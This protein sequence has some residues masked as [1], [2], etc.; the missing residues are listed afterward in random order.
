MFDNGEEKV[1]EIYS[2]VVKKY[3]DEFAF[4][5][6]SGISNVNQNDGAMSEG[7]V[8]N[9]KAMVR[10]RVP[11]NTPVMKE[12]HNY[13][14]FPD[15]PYYGPSSDFNQFN[16]GQKGT[17]FVLVI[18]AL[19]ALVILVSVVTFSILKTLGM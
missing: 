3:Q 7:G 13:S 10:V 8:A 5:K 16:P 2:D 9:E 12:D 6:N 19:L 18:V 15:Y 1:L 14:D 4:A 17:S 11:S